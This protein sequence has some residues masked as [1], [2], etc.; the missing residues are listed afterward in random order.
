M[1]EETQQNLSD[2]NY[3]ILGKAGAPRMVFLHGIMG[4]LNNWLKV[5]TH[6]K[7]DFEILIFDQRGHGRSCHKEAYKTADYAKDLEYITNQLGWDKFHLIGHSSG[8]I[9]A[10][11]YTATYPDKVLSLCIEDISMEPRKD[12]GVKIEK[13]LLSIPTPF[14]DTA[15]YKTFFE[16]KVP[17][18]TKNFFQPNLLGSFLK[19]NIV[20][21]DNGQWQW[22]F[23]RNGVI[24]SLREA[25]ASSFYPQYFS[26]K[27]PILVIHGS[28]SEDLPPAEYAKML[29]HTKAQGVELSSGH[30]VHFEQCEEFSK[31]LLDFIRGLC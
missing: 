11:E 4:S 13:L 7:N 29:T 27:C 25:R 9:V 17:G 6:F 24:D 3:K 19:M 10:C 16:Q 18:L 2:W 1:K 8:G 23:H 31:A 26:I 20:E 22:R 5:V 14:K 12:I 21:K 30:W 15:S 28:R